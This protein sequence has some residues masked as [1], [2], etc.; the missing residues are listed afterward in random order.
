M[1]GDFCMRFAGKPFAGERHQQGAA[2]GASQCRKAALAF[3]HSLLDASVTAHASR[4]PAQQAGADD[5]DDD[6][7]A[8]HEFHHQFATPGR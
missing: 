2:N 8:V 7:K 1:P 5:D 6:R 3:T 4:D